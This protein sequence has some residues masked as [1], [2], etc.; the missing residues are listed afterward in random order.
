MLVGALLGV[1]I[2]GDLLAAR[3]LRSLS[4]TADA[5]KRGEYSALPTIRGG[6]REM[7]Q[8]ADTLAEIARRVQR[9]EAEL[10]RSVEQKD[11][12]LRDWKHRVKNNLQVVNSLIGLQLSRVQDERARQALIELLQRIN[13]LSILHLHLFG[14]EDVRLLDLGQ[15]ARDV[16]QTVFQSSGQDPHRVVLEVAV[17]YM[18]MPADRTVPVVLLIAEALTSALRNAFTGRTAGHVSIALVTDLHGVATVTIRDDGD[19]R[20]LEDDVQ[21]VERSPDLAS[22]LMRA[23]AQQID[24][25]LSVDGPPGTTIRFTFQPFADTI[26]EAPTER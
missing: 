19:F 3:G 25:A 11:A 18:A 14:E 26:A 6:S 5:L 9:N 8:L 4:R 22:L 17:P 12:L 1:A 15:I 21:S 24:A 16:C 2:G 10:R 7:R 23:F 13:T 20:Q